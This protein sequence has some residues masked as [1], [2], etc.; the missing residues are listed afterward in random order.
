MRAAGASPMT[1]SMP[2]RLGSSAEGP[3]EQA[4]SGLQYDGGECLWLLHGSAVAGQ[5]AAD[6][7]AIYSI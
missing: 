7:V 6:L 2:L 1:V 4:D 3:T 5:A